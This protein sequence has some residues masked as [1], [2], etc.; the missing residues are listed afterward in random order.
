MLPILICWWYFAAVIDYVDFLRCCFDIISFFAL[1]LPLSRALIIDAAFDADAA[2]S[3]ALCCWWCCHASIIIDY[4]FIWWLR[5]LLSLI[6]LSPCHAAAIFAMPLRDIHADYAIFR[7]WGCWLFSL[8]ADYYYFRHCCHYWC[9]PSFSPLRLDITRLPSFLRHFRCR[10]RCFRHATMS[11]CLLA[12]SYALMSPVTLLMPRRFSRRRALAFAMSAYIDT[13][14]LAIIADYVAA[15]AAMMLLRWLFDTRCCRFS[16][17]LTLSLPICRFSLFIIYFAALRPCDADTFRRCDFRL[18]RDADD[19]WALIIFA[20]SRLHADYADDTMLLLP[21]MLPWFSPLRLFHAHIAD[22]FVFTLIYVISFS[23]LHDYMLI[24]AGFSSAAIS[25]IFLLFFIDWFLH[26]FRLMLLRRCDMPITLSMLAITTPCRHAI[27]MPYFADYFLSYYFAIADAFADAAIIH[28]IFAAFFSSFSPPWLFSPMLDFHDYWLRRLL[29]MPLPLYLP[30]HFASFLRCCWCSPLPL[31]MLP[32]MPLFLRRHYF[33]RYAISP[34]WCWYAIMP[35]YFDDAR[36]CRRAIDASMLMMLFFIAASIAAISRCR[37][38]RWYFRRHFSASFIDVFAL[39]L[40]FR[41][42]ATLRFTFSL[43][44][45]S[46]ILMMPSRDVSF[47]MFMFR[48]RL[49]LLI[50][51]SS[52]PSFH[53]ATAFRLIAALRFA[54]AISM[55]IFSCRCLRHIT[56]ATLFSFDY[57]CRDTPPF[58]ADAASAVAADYWC[59]ADAAAIIDDVSMPWYR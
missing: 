3:R 37:W 8:H 29:L 56:R 28:I 55:M 14:C 52:F 21:L 23:S 40:H 6:M 12:S 16:A 57:W 34:W 51:V 17:A 44:S 30:R 58:A 36:H 20:A 39:F 11:W 24:F 5:L 49:L 48:L 53:F 41:Y 38:L 59:H 1:R 47:S 27:I 10:L 15:D 9:P 50:D 7:W 2:A 32:L 19:C 42:F 25:I 54:A 35:L 46:I 13:R 33:S 26:L 31:M 22:A 43:I 18:I 45:I 4:A